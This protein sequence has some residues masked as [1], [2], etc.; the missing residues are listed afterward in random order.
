MYEVNGENT[1][2][3]F[4]NQNQRKEI[5]P[6]WFI[7]VQE[8]LEG[9]VWGFI[10]WGG[11]FLLSVQNLT[12]KIY[13]FSLLC[14]TYFLLFPLRIHKLSTI[15]ISG[16]SP[17]FNPQITA[18]PPSGH[19]SLPWQTFLPPHE[20]LSPPYSPSASERSAWRNLSRNLT[21]SCSAASARWRSCSALWRSRSARSS[22]VKS[23]LPSLSHHRSQGSST[24]L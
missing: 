16:T 21:T 5:Y 2:Q 22:P 8:I 10:V 7:P 6:L 12:Y 13:A 23:K 20:L 18:S 24:L 1:T 15:G 14:Q 17:P 4:L 9:F 3:C 19:S 11:G